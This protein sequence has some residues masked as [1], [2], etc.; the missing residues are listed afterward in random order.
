MTHSIAGKA[1]PEWYDR[2][3]MLAHLFCAN[4]TG[5]WAGM[6]LSFDISILLWGPLHAF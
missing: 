5:V 6:Y 2:I 3:E 1:R 4:G